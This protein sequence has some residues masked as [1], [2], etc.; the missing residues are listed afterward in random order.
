MFIDFRDREREGHPLVA[1]STCPGRGSNPQP[2]GVVMTP[3]P[4]E[5]PGQAEDFFVVVNAR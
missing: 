4:T 1:S 3:Q 5:P 2:F